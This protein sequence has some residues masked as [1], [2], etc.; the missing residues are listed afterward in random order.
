MRHT[1]TRTTHIAFQSDGRIL[2]DGYMR[3]QCGCKSRSVSAQQ[4]GAEDVPRS[5]KEG[6]ILSTTDQRRGG[7]GVAEGQDRMAGWQEEQQE[8]RGSRREERP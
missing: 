4:S 5:R 6:S 7:K 1:S 2:S 8:E 3:R